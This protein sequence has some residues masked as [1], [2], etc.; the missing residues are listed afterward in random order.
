MALL[1]AVCGEPPESH[2]ACA[3][4]GEIQ[5]RTGRLDEARAAFER[6]VRL[7]P[8][9]L[10]GHRYLAVIAL[11]RAEAGA[12]RMAAERGLAIAPD[13]LELGYL[14]R[15]AAGSAAEVRWRRAADS[16]P[17]AMLVVAALAFEV[18]DAGGAAEGLDRGIALWPG[19]PS[20]YDSRIRIALSRNDRETARRIAEA[21]RS[22]LPGDARA[23]EVLRRLAQDP[24]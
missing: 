21:W 13:D 16:G 14:Q 12:A 11:A 9:L 15:R 2:A 6:A 1:G 5:Y 10:K 19:E 23:G 17:K 18:G 7:K 4:L 8:D 3:I 22:H 20:L 24:R